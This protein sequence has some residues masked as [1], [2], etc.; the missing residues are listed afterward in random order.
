MPAILKESLPNLL[1]SPLYSQSYAPI[2]VTV[3]TRPPGLIVS[4]TPNRRTV[5]AWFGPWPHSLDSLCS[6]ASCSILANLTWCV[7]FGRC[8]H[9]QSLPD[10]VPSVRT[11]LVHMVWSAGHL[12]ILTSRHMQEPLVFGQVGTALT[13]C[14]HRLPCLRS[15][16]PPVLDLYHPPPPRRHTRTHSI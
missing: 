11:G 13:R 6:L 10:P 12:P 3:G 14:Y 9:Y 7:G 4:S 1:A 16:S 15:E 8:V 5:C 2:E